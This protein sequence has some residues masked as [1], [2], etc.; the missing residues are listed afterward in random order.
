[1]RFTSVVLATI[2]LTAT[3]LTTWPAQASVRAGRARALDSTV[4]VIVTTRFDTTRRCTGFMF[5]H[6]GHVL[7]NYHVVS[8]AVD[9]KVMHPAFGVFE[10]DC[11]KRIDPRAN[12]AV[13]TVDNLG[14]R[15]MESARIADSRLAKVGD[16]VHV[17][18][19]P[20]YGDE[21]IFDAT[22]LSMGYSRQFPGSYVMDNFANE[23]V[24]FELAGPFDVG[25]A[26]GIVYN[27]DYE[28]IGLIVGA[29]A[30]DGPERTTYALASTYFQS[31]LVSSYDVA[32]DA[33][34]SGYASD[35]EYFDMF[36]GPAP[37]VMDYQAP[38][39]EGYI[40]WFAP[41][42]PTEYNDYEFTYEI[43]DKIDKNWFATDKLE[44]DGRPVEE[45]SASRIFIWPAYV[46]PW[47]I[48]DSIDRYVHFDADSLF[49]KRIYAD[50][51]TEERIMTRY[52]LCMALE[53]GQHTLSYMNRGANYKATGIKRERVNISAAGIELLDIQG[54]SFVSM[55]LLPNA[56]PRA[57]EGEPVR[58]ELERRPLSDKEVN[59]CVRLVRYPTG[60]E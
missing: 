8:D 46:N 54:L 44:I 39:P 45:W 42:Y 32:W 23:M 20:A 53:P 2:I 26:G 7:T 51:D 5:S 59:A 6:N 24:V 29:E 17:L 60:I 48:T 52:I 11:V 40:A 18:H 3:L 34:R 14:E 36:L 37:Q 13:L 15:V 56:M 9:I 27:E 50:R 57:G 58:Y 43:N 30:G 41:C 16:V 12:V 25:S 19:H 28:A 10:V 31:L 22:I 33:L 35:A 47:E 1:M 4:Q 38:M 49:S 21:V 55:L